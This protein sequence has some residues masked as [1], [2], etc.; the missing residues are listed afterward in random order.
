VGSRFS[1]GIFAHLLVLLFTSKGGLANF[2]CLG[3]KSKNKY[4]DLF[5]YRKTYA[6][7]CN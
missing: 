1:V 2:F 4:L 7:I 5:Y 3:R 6:L